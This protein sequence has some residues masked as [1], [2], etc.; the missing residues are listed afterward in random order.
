MDGRMTPAA[1]RSR[2]REVDPFQ[3][4]WNNIS[5]EPESE[6]DFASLRVLGR[7]TV[8][9]SFC[10]KFGSK[11][12]VGAPARTVWQ[13]I[14]EESHTRQ[15]ALAAHA[16]QE[17]AILYRS[18]KGRI[19]VK[20]RI[21]RDHGRITELRFE[22]CNGQA[23]LD[24]SIENVL[25]LDEGATQRLVDLCILMKGIDPAGAE[26]IKFDE[27]LLSAVL[28]DPH[29]VAAAYARHPEDF[30]AAI[31]D[32][33]NAEDVI[34]VAAKRAALTHFEALLRDPAAFERA[35]GGGTRE[36]VWQRFFEANPWILG[37]GLSAH[38]FTSWDRSKLE[39]AVAG[40]SISN[41]GK[42]VDALMT[43]SGIVRSL[44]L[45]ELKLHDDPL[46]ESS[47][48]RSGSWAPSQQVTSGVA[49][50]HTTADRA[51][52]DIGTWLVE[53]DEQGYPTGD[54]VYSGAPRSYLVIGQLTSLVRNG[55][56]HP[57]KIRSFELFRHHLRYPE[58][59]TYDEVLARAKWSLERVQSTANG[60]S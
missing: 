45:A 8:S 26:T 59:L 5:P 2:P 44:T 14:A 16:D 57:D 60:D 51:R 49:Q 23:G 31:E 6:A 40:A 28:A 12:Y 19:Q 34:A 35:R 52:E 36:G 48:Y 11:S 9:K 10:L 4:D 53:R 42:R 41:A 38:L 1:A 24:A 56:A 50:A 55:Q 25:T 32:D 21:V 47:T 3:A 37:I 15:A 13:I 17:E 58:I 33:A 18:P 27:R 20:A 29:T 46:L 7:T 30:R 39:K 54:R 22:R 43:T